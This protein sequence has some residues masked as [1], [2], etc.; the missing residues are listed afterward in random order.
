MT[1]DEIRR[2]GGRGGQEVRTWMAAFAALEAVGDYEMTLH[3][4]EPISEWIAGFG[5]VSAELK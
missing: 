1:E 5:I 3:C 4:Y 2:E